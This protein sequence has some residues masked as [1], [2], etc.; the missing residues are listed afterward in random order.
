MKT[1]VPMVKAIKTSKR[2]PTSTV[3]IGRRGFAKISA[4]EG[5]KLSPEA[6]QDFREFDRLGLSPA[7]RRQ[8]LLRKYGRK[9]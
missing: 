2:R 5:I 9:S 3:T 8:A 1:I 7:A 6:E 4:V